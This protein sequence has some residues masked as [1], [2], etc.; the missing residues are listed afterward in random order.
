M[1]FHL[2]HDWSNWSNPIIGDTFSLVQSRKC[3]VCGKMEI[4]KISVVVDSNSEYKKTFQQPTIGKDI[5]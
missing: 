1:K 5:K 2:I 4:N 3:K